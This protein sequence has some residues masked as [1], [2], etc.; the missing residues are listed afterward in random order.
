MT[1]AA[2]RIP[3]RALSA[4]EALAT[5]HVIV[6]DPSPSLANLP[7]ATQNDAFAERWF[8]VPK[9]AWGREGSRIVCRLKPCVGNRRDNYRCEPLL[10]RPEIELRFDDDSTLAEVLFP[11][12]FTAGMARAWLAAELGEARPVAC[13]AAEWIV[14]D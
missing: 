13:G 2:E 3:E 4:V 7:F 6:G 1:V 8:A 10:D 9:P 14:S 12:D 5:A 11:A